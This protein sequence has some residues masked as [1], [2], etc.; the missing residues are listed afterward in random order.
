MACYPCIHC[1]KCGM[2]SVAAEI[3]CEAC[4]TLI[5]VGMSACPQCGGTKYSGIEL[6]YDKVMAE[7]AA[8]KAAQEATQA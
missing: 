2:Y 1:N 3:R 5:T 8:K 4:G 7:R 6:D